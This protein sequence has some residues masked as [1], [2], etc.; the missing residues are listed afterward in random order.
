MI[1][2][3]YAL[4]DLERKG[5]IYSNERFTTHLAKNLRSYA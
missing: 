4:K 5:F 3:I 1:S 2:F